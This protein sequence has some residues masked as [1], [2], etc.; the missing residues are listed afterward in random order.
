MDKTIVV[1]LVLANVV[2]LLVLHQR[3]TAIGWDVPLQDTVDSLYEAVGIGHASYK[4]CGWLNTTTF[5]LTSSRVVWPDGVRPGA[6]EQLGGLPGGGPLSCIPP[7][8]DIPATHCASR[9]T[10]WLLQEEEQTWMMPKLFAP[11]VA[12]LQ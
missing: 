8:H 9:F 12:H 6:G 3:L 1:W 10:P 4:Q 11:A 5:I 2:A 7:L